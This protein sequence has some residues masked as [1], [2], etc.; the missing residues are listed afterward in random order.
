[1][2]A[3]NAPVFYLSRTLCSVDT[4]LAKW[5]RTPLF[6]GSLRGAPAEA[7]DGC[8]QRG[9]SQTSRTI[10]KP[11]RT[12]HKPSRTIHKHGYDCSVRFGALG[13]AVVLPGRIISRDRTLTQLERV[14]SSPDGK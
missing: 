14:L 7:G 11:S 3:D 2:K 5:T 13:G 10:H 8:D 1:M 4:I 12:I 6:G 9:F